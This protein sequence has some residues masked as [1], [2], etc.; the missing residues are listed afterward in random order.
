MSP[1][2][3][4]LEL[5][6][7]DLGL[8]F[9]HFSPKKTATLTS[10]AWCSTSSMVYLALTQ[11]FNFHYC[12]FSKSYEFHYHRNTYLPSPKTHHLLLLFH[13]HWTLRIHITF[14]IYQNSTHFWRPSP[15]RNSQIIPIFAKTLPTRKHFHVIL[16]DDHGI[17]S[18]WGGRWASLAQAPSPFWRGLPW[19]TLP[20]EPGNP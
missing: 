3:L 16:S 17:C 10:L 20:M 6:S 15:G 13:A 5:S 1:L 11:N 2:A 19:G 8:D 4:P 7:W 12:T 14:S 18:F 9:Y